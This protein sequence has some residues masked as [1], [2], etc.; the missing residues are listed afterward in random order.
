MVILV[1]VLEDLI[2][3]DTKTKIVVYPEHI[4]SNPELLNIKDTI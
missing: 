3:K 2:T 1:F 4:F